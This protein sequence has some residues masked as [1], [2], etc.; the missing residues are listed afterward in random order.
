MSDAPAEVE[1]DGQK[2][3]HTTAPEVRRRKRRRQVAAEQPPAE[4]TSAESASTDEAPEDPMERI[5]ARHAS[6]AAEAA[7][8]PTTTASDEADAEVIPTPEVDFVDEDGEDMPPPM[9]PKPSLR[10]GMSSEEIDQAATVAVATLD[11]P[12]PARNFD[13]LMNFDLG[14]RWYVHVVR[15]TPKSYYGKRVDGEQKPI[16]RRMTSKEFAR[17]YGGLEYDLTVY[18]P[19]KRGDHMDPM[20]GQP[21]FVARTKPIRVTMS[22]A[23]PNPEM[24]VGYDPTSEEDEMESPEGQ[25]PYRRP[26]PGIAT[27]ADARIHETDLEHARTMDERAERRRRELKA[28]REAE[29]KR[30]E[31]ERETREAST[32]D[33]MARMHESSMESQRELLRAT[34]TQIAA[35][36]GA[37]EEENRYWHAALTEMQ[38]STQQYIGVI[39]DK[40]AQALERIEREHREAR[41]RSEEQHRGEITR[42]SDQVTAER[43]RG[44]Q[45]IRDAER[46]Y[47][48][49]VRD[50]EARAQREIGEER[51][52]AAERVEVLR[53]EQTERT[54][55]MRREETQR[56]DDERQRNADRHQDLKDAHERD[57][58]ARDNKW[59]SQLASE[60]AGFDS[61]MAVKEHELK[62]LREENKRLESE[63]RKPIHERIH[64]ITKTARALGMKT[65][66]EIETPESAEELTMQQM[67]MRMG[68]NVVENLPG[69]IS[70]ASDAVTR[71]RQGGT[72][73]QQAAFVEQQHQQMQRGA[74][75][76][77][78]AQRPLPFALDGENDFSPAVGAPPA[79]A[80]F[81]PEEPAPL[82]TPTAPPAPAPSAPPPAQPP[83]VA[84]PIQAAQPSSPPPAPNAPDA[85]P[86]GTDPAPPQNGSSDTAYDP[87]ILQLVEPFE[88]AMAHGFAPA[89]VANHIATK[90][91]I[92]PALLGTVVSRITPEAVRGALQRNGRA[93][94]PLCRRDGQKY[95]RAVQI[96]LQ[97][98]VA[99]G[100]PA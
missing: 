89:D 12:G 33:A 64:D 80:Q 99:G 54:E 91:D 10:R 49:R 23:P 58:R 5:A 69:I 90:A 57:L 95:L 87:V 86:A 62:L 53:R 8:Q 14:D 6:R 34:M 82:M 77:P 28:E 22:G 85:P 26:R 3:S 11:E 61:K 72:P 76:H 66:D 63:N 36:P 19:P 83:A 45:A 100:P 73:A 29:R 37:G 71:L 13:D 15:R 42:L 94:S 44:D 56:R 81:R 60:R 32:A 47:N 27:T 31:R 96:E 97:K 55:A 9:E 30:E 24:A 50:I 16:T 21:I 38:K 70:S 20:S 25:G 92:P 75:Q 52:R 43:N 84:A 51:T 18:G 98:I 1:K 48:D 46:A 4:S 7:A 40:H 67:I 65:P 93:A 68:A 59:E 41:E 78:L 88:Q 79:F 35:R 2:L 39:N 74:A 17:L